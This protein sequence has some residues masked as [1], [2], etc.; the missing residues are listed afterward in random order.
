MINSDPRNVFMS[1]IKSR[2]EHA[3]VQKK[4]VLSKN[5]FEFGPL[6]VLPEAAR[7]VPETESEF[8]QLLKT[9][10]NNVEVFRMSN[11]SVFPIRID[12]ALEKTDGDPAFAI[13]PSYLNIP[14][15]ETREVKLWASPTCDGFQ[16]NALVCCV[17]DNP[18]P[19][20]FSV[21]CFGCTPAL[22]LR[23]PWEQPAANS[24]SESDT[25]PRDSSSAGPI[26][27]F[28]QLL[29]KR[30][31]EKTFFIE[32]VSPIAVSWSL[33]C[34]DLPPDFRIFP[35]E[36]TIK[37][38]QKAPVIVV[39]TANTE[40]VYKLPIQIQFSDAESALKVNDRNR[41]V[42]LVI[43][44]EAY[45]IEVSSFEK[46][47]AATV[48]IEST[49][50]GSTTTANGDG[51]LDFGLA[52]VGESHSR[53][54]TIRNRG[55]YNIKYV[56]SIR[57]HASRELFKIE[58]SEL[59][60]EPDK[61]SNVNVTFFSKREVTL[62]DCKDIKCTIIE[63]ISGEPCREFT[64][65]TT[66]RSVF[67]VFRVQPNRGINFGPH[68]YSD[69]AKSKRMEIRNDGEFPF[70]FRIRPP[71]DST[72]ASSAPD[73][74]LLSLD[75]PL[76]PTALSIGQFS[77]SPDC[78]IVDPGVTV[79]IDVTFQPIDCKA[80][81]E[82]VHIEISGRNMLDPAGA[83]SLQYELVGESC[84]PGITTNDFESIFEEQ[85]VVRS[86]GLDHATV[87]AQQ[88]RQPSSSSSNA[89]GFSMLG[90]QSVVFAEK[91]Q[92]FSFGALIAAANS[93][94][95]VERF[96]I[97]NPT[98]VT[99]T[100]QF[101]VSNSSHGSGSIS[102]IAPAQAFMAQPSVWEIPPLEHRFVSVYFKPTT[103]ASYQAVFTAK[104]DESPPQATAQSLTNDALL[105]F[106]LRGEGTMPCVSIMEP[107]Q[108]D[109]SGA[110]VLNYGRVRVSKSKDLPIILRNDGILSATVL[111]S[112]TS[113]PNFF[114][115]LG[116]G[117]VSIAPKATETL[118]IQFKPQKMHDEATTS[119]LK[120]TVHNN[121]FD[122]TIVKLAGTGY[123]EDLVFE[124]LPLGHDDELYFDDIQLLSEHHQ[125]SQQ[126]ANSAARATDV[127]VF[128]L[129]NQTS[130]TVRFAWPKTMPP[131]SFT[132]AV[133]HLRPKS[134]KLITGKFSP[135]SRDTK[136]AVIY[137][138][139]P[140]ALQ[141][142][143]IAY[144]DLT[145]VQSSSSSDWDENART[146]TFEGGQPGVSGADETLA[147][148]AF[149]TIGAP[150]VITLSC[151]AAADAL[152]FDCDTT[153]IV[154]KRTFMLQACSHRISV[155]N[156]SKIKLVYS[157]RFER[158]FGA[159]N[160]GFLP[161]V[162][163]S[164]GSV[165]DDCPF[166]IS[167]EAGTI[168]AEASQV[169]TVKFAPMEVDEFHYT[170][171]LEA[172]SAH[173]DDDVSRTLR[174]DVRGASLRPACHFDVE[175]SDYAQRRAPH[176]V[177]PNGELGP[178]DHSVKV[179]EMESLG[180]RVRNTRRFYVVNPTNVSY[181]FTWTPE[182]EVNPC[183]RCATP[184]GL[185]LAGKRC[186]MIFEFT[187]QQLELQ[188][189]FWRFQIPHFQVNQ[190]FLFV[191]T[192]TEPR[193]IL[194]RG[195]VN[196]NT[197]LIGTK[198]SQ[199]I[200]LVNHEHIPF[201]FVFDKSSLDFANEVP[202]LLV[203][204]LS[205]VI[206][207][208]SRCNIDIEFVPT[209]EKTYNFNL[210]CI[211]KRKPTRLSLNV[212]GEGY[213]IHDALMIASDD[214]SETR[215]VVLGIGN[216]VDFGAVRVNEELQRCVMI[217][218]MGKFN[219]E[220]NWSAQKFPVGFSIEPMQ[221]TVK[222]TDKVAC[223]L[224]FAPS[225]QTSLDGA[226]V[227]C[228]IAGSRHY[229]FALHGN[230]VP[231]SLQLSFTA[232]DF[233]A[234]FVAEPDALPIS[235]TVQ[236][237]IFNMDPEIGIDLDCLFE[238][239]P[240]LRVE[241]PPTVL[242]PRESV[243]IPI[244]FT[245]RQEVSYIEMVPFMINGG[246][247]TINISIRGEGITPKVELVNPAAMQSV[248]FSALQIE[249]QLSRTIKIVNRAKRKITVDVVDDDSVPGVLSLE[250]LSISILS[251]REIVLRPK[252]TADI[253]FK[254]APTKR[255]PAFQKDVFL[256]VAGSKKKLVTLSGCCQGMEVALD[257]DT[258]L[259]GTVCLG[260]QLVRKVRL[261]NRGDVAAKFQWNPRAFAPDF[262][263]SPAEGMVAPN[264]HKALEI[265][266]KP[267]AVNPDLRY[268]HLTCV[269][270]G[271]SPVFLTLVGGCIKQATS[272][273][274]DIHFESRVRES[275]TKHI[276]IENTSTSPWNLFPVVTGEHWSCQENVTIPA[277]GKTA[278]DIVYCPLRMTK[279]RSSEIEVDD[280]IHHHP[281]QLEGSIFFAIPDGTALLYNVFGK[282]TAPASAGTIN[283]ST[284]AKKTLPI[285]VP[286]KNWLKTA[287]TFD[288]VVNKSNESESV[289]AQG[290]S[291]ITVQGSAMRNYNLKFFSYT[292]GVVAL[293]LRFMNPESG[294]YVIYDVNVTVTQATE[295][296]T[297]QFEAPVRQSLKKT[298]TI[299]NPFDATRVVTFADPENWW[300]CSSL[301]IRVRQ[302][303]EIMGRPEGSYEVEYRPTL[304][305]NTPAE[306]S[307]TIS[308]AELGEYTYKLVLATQPAGVERILHFKA[309]LGGS[310]TQNFAFTTFSDKSADVACSIQQPTFFSVPNGLKIDGTMDWEGK[311][312]AVQIKFEPEALG[313]IRDTLTLFADTVGEYKCTLHGVS[314]PPLP[315]GP[316]VFAASS[317]R[318]IEFR[319]VFSTHKDFEV[320]VD[321]PRFTLS[322]KS[323]S[324]PAKSS[325]VITV[326][327][328]PSAVSASAS[329]TT[330]SAS[331]AGKPAAA[332]SSQEAAP[333]LLT[334]K[335][336]V[337]CP[338]Q[339]ELP[340]WV[341]YLE[342][343]APSA[344]TAT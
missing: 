73:D 78:G 224:L 249:Q 200:A 156:K 220:F 222:K 187:P 318:E 155:Q 157:W 268:D 184:K 325:K 61:V 278:V 337:S 30:Q 12:F 233:G 174:V 84:F 75:T 64:V 58:P 171:V 140:I 286:M 15:G 188:E 123:K 203:H 232:H 162:S 290:P 16:E 71:T 89:L 253:E 333:S 340:S 228:T 115:A 93:K 24:T 166:E 148:P 327:V 175:R 172:E 319:N 116:N 245:A 25:S 285:A 296:E 158:A 273:I 76:N 143:R 160:D 22:Q 237:N 324:I 323:L 164:S 251:P 80:Y 259:F 210:S 211:V 4:F 341:Y 262:T 79:G 168:A 217:H 90:I 195:S 183:F 329:G 234:C 47:S 311:N 42:P 133:G 53:S 265:T 135:E 141:A 269:L 41:V 132:P 343:T 252:E 6:I 288:V 292:E 313:E 87:S 320:M 271:A 13:H 65:F 10:P 185:M 257:T 291:S 246:S 81:R 36:G 263:I 105:Q 26:L 21:S 180:V 62:R 92:I 250:A 72:T 3:F 40:A 11:S 267:A 289:R 114:F 50:G 7:N 193:V 9:S 167:P 161:N 258:L 35:M 303:T 299:E 248:T 276:V 226:Q 338:S 102:E 170:L 326:K 98:K 238:K 66:V 256:N 240:H 322:T 69:L 100:V 103:I 216:L 244:V 280:S 218:N 192:T 117:S 124:D 212:K 95:T 44:A 38:L 104:V 231:P 137:H 169:F 239:K 310:Q 230:A 260:S 147:E 293:T 198:A 284:P 304:H 302:L 201:N 49:N 173:N 307:L 215:S 279:Q 77:V 165:D 225:K 127:K 336:F 255:I 190:L 152:S 334:G 88:Q 294:E 37:S 43:A 266:F 39:F 314:V 68:K 298:I 208:N 342:T 86:L 176:L 301:A 241:C 149:E 242:G 275:A 34:G 107:T 110:L 67:S 19:A 52:R 125:N 55:K 247:S 178:L 57:T 154:F 219:F 331:T 227:A 182:A 205:G 306:A 189:M 213:S 32:N 297:L 153:S 197:L 74:D 214:Q 45:K 48:G 335:L 2:P 120:I 207:P 85:I 20:L 5:Q 254:F 108:R 91:E 54:F 274:Q 130:D 295:I 99:T 129:C 111:F 202:T 272:S 122:E 264:Y 199:S 277:E 282:A 221:G 131:F 96:K 261:Q 305:L 316:F 118:S 33:L 1:R 150:A 191:G 159:D 142:Q 146:V 23:G 270:E 317:A 204:P 109:A 315:Q 59:I 236:L 330:T 17:S 106:E 113:N 60:L 112:L 29:L 27:D 163:S 134:Y 51:S 177:G 186:E 56:L 300:Q 18:E 63:M 31:E 312:H 243:N 344:A 328:D 339:K 126:D 128:S 332:S 145:A 94:G 281:E 287:Q 194:D 121:P 196:F 14:E 70:K 119:L 223:K 309:P 28:E 181:E 144:R 136:H 206:P 151:F 179:I 209:E 138:A 97:T 139:H 83:D 8:A 229:V 321:N 82:F 101:Q 283:V 235:E 308:F 46:M